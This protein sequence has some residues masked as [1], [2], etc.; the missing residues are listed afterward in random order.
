MKEEKLL[1]LKDV[2]S[3]YGEIRILHDVNISINAGEI[4]VLMG[5]NGAGKSTILKTVFG[6]ISHT[7]GIF[8]EGQK[9]FPLPHELVQMGIAFY[10]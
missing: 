6:L 4:V 3:G 7:G 8:Y 5:P 10:I 2:S 9:I 1:E